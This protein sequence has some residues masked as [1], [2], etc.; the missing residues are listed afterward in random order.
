MLKAKDHIIKL[1][2][3]R[4]KFLKTILKLKAMHQGNKS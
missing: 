2:K 1:R 3:E 4:E